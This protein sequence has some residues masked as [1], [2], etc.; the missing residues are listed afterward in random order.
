MILLI[1]PAQSNPV[2]APVEKALALYQQGPSKAPEIIELLTKWL[3]E[4][5]DDVAAH[6]LLGVT[7]HGVG[8]FAAALE[9]FNAALAI[10]GQRTISP[11]LLL[12][13]ASTLIQLDRCPEALNILSVYEAFW[14]KEEDLKQQAASTRELASRR[15]KPEAEPDE[16]Q[17]QRALVLSCLGR[18]GS[19]SFKGSLAVP[20]SRPFASGLKKDGDLGPFVQ[21]AERK[22]ASSLVVFMHPSGSGP[23]LVVLVG[24]AGPEWV[25]RVQ[26]MPCTLDQ[27]LESCE[28][29]V[30]QGPLL[31]N[32]QTLLPGKVTLDDESDVPAFTLSSHVEKP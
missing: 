24:K 3:V 31:A 21:L 5:P 20:I 29:P 23:A 17:R 18:L 13:K 11:R 10:Q 2:P 12:L 7:Y 1:A 30:P 4:H 32:E 22:Q 28:V 19:G 15:C 6:K 14:D 26:K 9:Q 16:H 27:L 8:N 25:S